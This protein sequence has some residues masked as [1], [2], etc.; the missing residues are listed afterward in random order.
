M[1]IGGLAKRTGIGIDAVRYYEREGLVPPAARL[2]SGYRV[3]GED[4]VR[5]IQFVQRAKA[6][7]FTLTEIRELLELSTRREDD[8]GGLKT[9]ATE[10]LADVETK[11]A[12]LTRIRDGLQ[13]LITACPGHGALER[14]PILHALVE[15][16]P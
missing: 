5:R 2:A 14:C 11:L 8:M 15:E 13:T 10:K 12:E 9:A 4:D 3:Y 16:Q 7:G 6:L 1:K